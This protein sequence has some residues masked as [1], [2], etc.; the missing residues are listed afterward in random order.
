MK[1]FIGYD[2]REDIAYQVCKYS[3]ESRNPDAE[4]V[5]LKQKELKAAGLYWREKDLLSSTEFTFS[6]FLV[7]VMAEY[8]GWAI[9]CDCDFLWQ[10]DP[11]EIMKYADDKYAVMVVKHDY[12]PPEGVKMDGQK[13]LPYPRKNWS[14]MILWNCAHPANRQITPEIVNTESGQYLHRFSWLKDEEIGELGKEWN[15]L[16]NHYHEPQ[17]GSPVAIHYTEGGPWFNNYHHCEYGYHWAI[18]QEKYLTSLE[19]KIQ[20]TSLFNCLPTDIETVFNNILKYRVDPLGEYYDITRESID[21]EIDMINTNKINAIDSEFRYERK[22]AKYDP[23]LQSFVQGC[24]G[25]I[26]TWD[27]VSNSA[28]PVVIRGITKRKEMQ[29]CRNAGR[30]FYYIDTGYFGNGRHKTYHRITLNDVQY[31]GPIKDRPTDRLDRTNVQFHKFTS[32]RNILLAPP[33]QKLL[34][35]YDINLEEWMDQTISEIKKYTDRPIVVRT[36]QGRSVRTSTDT[37]EMAL[38]RD[39]HCL[40]TYTSIAA[41]EALLFGKPAITL[42]PNAAAPLCSHSISEIENLAVPTV[43]EVRRWAAHLAYC[44]FNETEMKD[45]TAWRIL[46]NA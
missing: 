39:V 37:M 15:W 40:V 46:T 4:V 35:L 9:F 30:D 1:I 44:Q 34:N 42:G 25:Q 41:G 2:A 26:S 29:A 12:T 23:T 8:Q 32:G 22:G 43:D 7:P 31:F 28:T 17:D 33:S 36:K 13:Q 21:K 20:N 18:E 10:I 19:P 5:K 45:G 14:S 3:I 38:S 27:R 16:V 6:R 24:G 11:A